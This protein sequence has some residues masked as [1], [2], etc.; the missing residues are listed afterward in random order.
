[1]SQAS[2]LLNTSISLCIK[3]ANSC[4]ME[5]SLCDFGGFFYVTVY[6]FQLCQFYFK[7]SYFSF[8]FNFSSN[9]FNQV[10]VEAR[11]WADFILNY[12]EK[13]RN[14]LGLAHFWHPKSRFLWHQLSTILFST[15]KMV[16]VGLIIFLVVAAFF[17][18]IF[19]IWFWKRQQ[20]GLPI[21]DVTDS[22]SPGI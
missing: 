20:A 19:L 8:W 21:F 4:N 2:S 17:G 11:H 5:K 6:L 18:I 10:E 7:T 12:G 15:Y 16:L 1:M 3:Y 13:P 14:A 22:V 9:L